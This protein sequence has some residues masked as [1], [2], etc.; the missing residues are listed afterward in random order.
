[1]KRVLLG[2]ISIMVLYCLPC[3]SQNRIVCT[4]DLKTNY[5]GQDSKPR[6]IVVA[7]S[8]AIEVEYEILAVRMRED[9]LFTGCHLLDIS[10]FSEVD[11]PECPATSLKNDWFIVPDGCVAQVEVTEVHY[12]DFPMELGPARQP[13]GDGSYETYSTA[14]VLPVK[15]YEGLSPQNPVVLEEVQIYRGVKLQNVRVNPIQ[16]NYKERKVRVYSTLSYKVSLRRTA[17]QTLIDNA[18]YRPAITSLDDNMFNVAMNRDKISLPAYAQSNDTTAMIIITTPKFMSAVERYVELKKL[19]GYTPHIVSRENWTSQDV[20]DVVK[21]A[22]LSMPTL[23][24]MVIVGDHQDVPAFQRSV[25]SFVTDYLYC[26][27]DGEDDMFADIYRGRIPASNLTE[28]INFME[29]LENYVVNPVTDVS[30]YKN[31]G[32]CAYFQDD[33]TDGYEDRRFIQTAEEISIYLESL[34]KTINRIYCTRS[35]VNPLFWNNGDYSSGKSL[36]QYLKRPQFAW[37]GDSLDVV[38]LINTGSFLMYHRD[39]GEPNGWGDPKFKTSHLSLLRNMDKYPIIFSLNCKT[40]QFQDTCFAENMLSMKKT[41][42]IGIYAATNTSYSKYNDILACGLV[43][44]IW[45]NPGF[46]LDFPKSTF[47]YKITSAVS[48]LGE[49]LDSG[50]IFLTNNYNLKYGNFTTRQL[51][52]CFGD[53]TMM[54]YKDLPDSFGNVVVERGKNVSVTLTDH[55]RLT[56]VNRKTGEIESRIFDPIVNKECIYETSDVEY[57][58]VCVSDDG[59]IPY[60]VYGDDPKCVYIQNETLLQSRNFKAESIRIGSSVTR[61]RT[62]GKVEIR[63]GS[64]EFNASKEVVIEPETNISGNA[65]V[66]INVQ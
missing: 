47:D 43:N 6:R 57:I 50:F 30:F 12:K 24:Y 39:H 9:P 16:Y 29:K 37:D 21:Q 23:R 11:E 56:F 2:I 32:A 48:T 14:N 3:G 51:F 60:I 8:T 10:G 13:L 22:Y 5:T 52:H 27:M 42:C 54:V 45:P 34:D 25:K 63:E 7:G 35:D 49:I 38:N 28:A 33:D 20:K 26:C 64:Y 15:A 53:P 31:V 19:F 55:G 41:G 59:K 58:S 65:N 36:P 66:R 46:V 62:S 18:R 40:G 1:M 17:V 4:A 44:S 61:N